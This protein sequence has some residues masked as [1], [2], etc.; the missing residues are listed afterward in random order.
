MYLVEKDTSLKHHRWIF[1]DDSAASH[2]FEIL[3]FSELG[4]V[5]NFNIFNEFE[6]EIEGSVVNAGVIKIKKMRVKDMEIDLENKTLIV[7]CEDGDDII[8]Y[9]VDLDES[10]AQFVEKFWDES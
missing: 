3:I 5:K 9:C 1:P 10:I 6:I 8:D 7:S 4:L 2:L